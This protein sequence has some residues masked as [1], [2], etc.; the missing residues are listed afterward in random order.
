MGRAMPDL[1]M[2]RHDLAG[3]QGLGNCKELDK[4]E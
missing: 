3:L 2:D 4:G 1:Y